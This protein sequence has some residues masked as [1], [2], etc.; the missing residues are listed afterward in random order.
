MEN[1]PE[2]IANLQVQI[3]ENCSEKEKR[4]INFYWE[5][6]D[7]EFVYTTKQVKELF[8]LSQIEMSKIISTHSILSFYIYCDTCTSYENQQ[9]KNRTKYLE[10][11]KVKRQR[12]YRFLFRCDRCKRIEKNKADKNIEEARKKLIQKFNNA[13]ES[14]NWNNLTHFEREILSSCLEMNFDQLKKKHGGQLGKESFIK[15]IKALEKIASLNLIQL[16]KN[17]P[18]SYINA[19]QHLPRLKEFSSEIKTYEKITSSYGKI[20]KESNELKFK[21][22]INENQFHPDSPLYAGTVNFKERIVIEPG[23][24]Y[25]F[26]VWPRANENLYLTMTPI[27][28]LEKLPIQ[29]RICSHP[30]SLQ[31]GITDFLNCLGKDI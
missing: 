14:K 6:K 1:T 20:N 16:N 2:K 18:N 3:S 8:E 4:I 26:G 30:I 7:T 29:K 11:K 31:E 22:T 10:L 13:I 5:F 19:Y 24:E 17:G 15:L 27:K 23:V 28:N 12:N 21:L 25:I 9:V